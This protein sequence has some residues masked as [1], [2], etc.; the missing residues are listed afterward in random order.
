[1][2]IYPNAKHAF[3]SEDRPNVY[4]HD[5]AEDSWKCVLAFFSEHIQ[6]RA[7]V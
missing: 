4:D 7:A 2:K 3:C 6:R 1:V 5:A